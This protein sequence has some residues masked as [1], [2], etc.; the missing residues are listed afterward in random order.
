MGRFEV[1]FRS[2]SPVTKL[3][4]AISITSGVVVCHRM[5]Y[6]PYVRR[7]RYREA[8]QWANAILEQE[9]NA[10]YGQDGTNNISY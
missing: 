4:M 3:L 1:W 9:E 6:A 5:F 10:E 8:E 2:S 7:K